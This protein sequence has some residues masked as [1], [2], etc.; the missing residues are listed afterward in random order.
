MITNPDGGTIT[1]PN[2]FTYAASSTP[3]VTSITP[4]SGP[5]TGGTAV[6]IGGT[7]FLAGATVTIGCA[8]ATNVVVAATS[9]TATTP[10]CA[11][12][13]ANVTVTNPDA[14]TDTLGGGFTYAVGGVVAPAIT[15]VAPSSGPIAGGT[16]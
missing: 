15:S 1:V 2:A 7:G 3:T 11:A 10:A 16:G 8:A 14:G 12:G 13:S 6:T 5:T 4:T 9:I